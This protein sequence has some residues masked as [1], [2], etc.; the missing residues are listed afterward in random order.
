MNGMTDKSDNLDATGPAP[1]TRKRR[2]RHPEVIS[3]YD[4][5]ELLGYSREHF[6]TI[7]E[8][9]GLKI[10]PGRTKTFGIAATQALF[11]GVDIRGGLAKI[12]AE[13]R[14]EKDGVLNPDEHAEAPVTDDFLSRRQP[15]PDGNPMFDAPPG[16]VRLLDGTF[17]NEDL[18]ISRR[19]HIVDNKDLYNPFV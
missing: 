18:W 10:L 8:E 6:F 1:K 2:K 7:Y 5:A 14:R 15:N 9:L 3:I 12:L 17:M 16:Y 13:R 4:L 19:A 11:P